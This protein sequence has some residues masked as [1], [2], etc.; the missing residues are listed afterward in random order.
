MKRLKTFLICTNEVNI[1]YI[2]RYI[3]QWVNA[4]VFWFNF[5]IADLLHYQGD[6][7]QLGLAEPT[8]YPSL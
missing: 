3:I 2:F 5:N 1:T 4:L 6:D 7:Q 8:S